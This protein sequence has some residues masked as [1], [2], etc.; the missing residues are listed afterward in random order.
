MNMLDTLDR[1][2]KRQILGETVVEIRY[3]DTD[4]DFLSLYDDENGYYIEPA[5]CAIKKITE[6]MYKDLINQFTDN[7]VYNT[8]PEIIDSN[9]TFDEFNNKY[10]N[11]LK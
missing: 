4:P 1:Q 10:Y 8:D 9:M 11:D 7:Q 2:I 5:F 6:N 3:T